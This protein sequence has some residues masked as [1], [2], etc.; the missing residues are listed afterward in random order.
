[1]PTQQQ[2]EPHPND[3]VVRPNNRGP[4]PDPRANDQTAY[5]RGSF[6]RAWELYR[7]LTHDR[8]QEL[9]EDRDW[10]FA[11]S[12]PDNPHCY[13]LRWHWPDPDLF[14]AVAIFIRLRGAGEWW[15]DVIVGRPYV[16][17]NLG[18]FRLWTMNDPLRKTWLINRK[19][20]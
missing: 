16:S 4:W 5:W 10:I 6:D 8:V 1:M 9:L 11:R 2:R 17:L 20:G 3:V 14:Y 15:P 13:S 19:V 7:D 18:G 12:M